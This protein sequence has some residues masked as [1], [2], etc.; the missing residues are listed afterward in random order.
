MFFDTFVK[1]A[2]ILAKCLHAASRKGP[3]GIHVYVA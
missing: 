3:D 2:D 1:Q